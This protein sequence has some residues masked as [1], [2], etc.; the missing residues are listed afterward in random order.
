MRTKA[1]VIKEAFSELSDSYKVAIWNMYARE[2][3]DDEICE[4][5]DDFFEQFFSSTMDAV[6]AICYG[7]YRYCDDWVKFNGY[8]NLDSTNYPEEWIDE[9]YL[10]EWLCDNEID[11]A[12]DW[13][14]IEESVRESFNDDLRE[15][16][17]NDEQIEAFGDFDVNSDFESNFNEFKASLTE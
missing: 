1:E 7:N 3:C 9:D 4:N 2:T 11:G 12:L 6:R 13:G 5:E 17:Y 8:G 14:D 16:G 10:C 15:M